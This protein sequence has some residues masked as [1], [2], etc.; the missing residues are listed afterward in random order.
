MCSILASVTFIVCE[1][2]KYVPLNQGI[3]N[4]IYTWAPD[5]LVLK[6]KIASI[7]GEG[8]YKSVVFILHGKSCY[9]GNKSYARAYRIYAY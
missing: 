3:C 6:W 9:A 5:D 2:I 1:L 8:L 4:N 7:S